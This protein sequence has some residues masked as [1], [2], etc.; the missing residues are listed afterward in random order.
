MARRQ[1]RFDRDG[2]I[3]ALSRGG[4]DREKLQNRV[5]KMNCSMKKVSMKKALKLSKFSGEL[6]GLDAAIAKAT[7]YKHALPKEK[8]IR[9]IF[10]SLSPSKPR[11]EVIY[12]IEGLTKRFSHTNNW[13][14]AMK[15]LLV[16]HR[17]IRELDSSIFEELLHYRNSKGYIIDFS[18]FHGTSAPTDFSIWI[19]HYALYLEERIQC[20]NV[21]NYDAATNSSVA[22][23][24]VKLYVAI[25][26]RVVE[27]LDKFFEM[28]HD[29][30]RSS[31]RIYKKSVTQAERLSEFFD[32]CKRLEFGRGR[33][34]INIKMPPASFIT[35]ME[36]YIKEAPSS[37]MLE[38][39]MDDNSK[40]LI[41]SNHAS[42][43]GDI[44]SINDDVVDKPTNAS[45]EN[46]IVVPQPAEL[47]GLHDLLT[48]ASEF[49]E[50]SLAMTFI[51]S[52]NDENR[53]SPE[54]GWEVALFTEPEN[55][56]GN[57]ITTEMENNREVGGM[58]LWKDDDETEESVSQFSRKVR[59]NPFD[60][61]G[62]DHHDEQFNMA[63]SNSL[64]NIPYQMGDM[65]YQHLV[66]Q[67]R[68]TVNPFDETNIFPST[69][70]THPTQTR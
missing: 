62:S 69:L 48:G 58:E 1:R 27:L 57:I 60:M 6:K 64:P 4:R 12:C 42:S 40:R 63:S 53:T 56:N 7:S 20:F 36:E 49:E 68:K 9:T 19:R 3:A 65:P 28:Y 18:F 51:P 35:T 17:A 13:S 34:F 39:N 2:T 33:K 30:A 32:T 47:M 26:I 38:D 66:Q 5:E 31:L 24:S 46:N 52:E 37:L 11:S 29:D 59:L 10:H 21:I 15:S 14:V 41:N 55:D 70:P 8:H 67:P 16:L 61:E 23:E 43:T 50:K 54:L 45:T 25:T 22:G 44:L